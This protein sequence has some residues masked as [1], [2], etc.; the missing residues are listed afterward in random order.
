MISSDEELHARVLERLQQHDPAEG[1]ASAQNVRS[2]LEVW[3]AAAGQPRPAGD[4]ATVTSWSR[5]ASDPASYTSMTRWPHAAMDGGVRLYLMPAAYE[6]ATY[7][8]ATCCFVC[9]WHAIWPHATVAVSY[10][11]SC[12]CAVLQARTP[13][14]HRT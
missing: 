10:A 12:A 1:W 11:T 6:T 4:C 9:S 8:T 5:A 7:E 2:K 14:A 3:M 13:C